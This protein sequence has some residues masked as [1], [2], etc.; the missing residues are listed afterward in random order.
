MGFAVWS[1][2]GPPTVC[3]G[4]MGFF[5][6]AFSGERDYIS[7]EQ[8]YELVWSKPLSGL[9]KDLGLSDAGLG[10]ICRRLDI[11]LPGRGAWMKADLLK[12]RPPLPPVPAGSKR[13]WAVVKPRQPEVDSRFP[14]RPEFP[15]DRRA[16]R[17]HFESLLG[18]F[19][20]ANTSTRHPEIRRTLREYGLTPAQGPV[21]Y[22]IPEITS[23]LGA[24]RARFA[25]SLLLALRR[26]GASV[27]I[28]D[29]EATQYTA[30]VD[31]QRVV[32]VID[33]PS[34]SSKLLPEVARTRL[35]VR[36]K[37]AS[38]RGNSRRT[39]NES[40]RSIESQLKEITLAI[41]LAAEDNRRALA[42]QTWQDE[43]FRI[44]REERETRAKA[45]AEARAF[46]DKLRKDAIQH[47]EANA[48]RELIRAVTLNL[49][50]S[51]RRDTWSRMALRHA[52]QLDPATNGTVLDRPGA[53]TFGGADTL[54]AWL[55]E[56]VPEDFRR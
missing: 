34:N 56:L 11:P 40:A 19:D 13:P 44:Q 38:G 51:E 47:S 35:M 29:R 32:F 46:T 27:A 52:E 6:P 5:A 42:V 41:L 8:L 12:R 26:A 43:V 25:N 2:T 16:R 24:R 21:H 48:I 45:L 10:K 14:P 49:P 55:A 39:W 7:R 23:R 28:E 9:A 31:G 36:L 22:G 50:P 33:T 15:N 1:M 30:L 17:V 4:P 20:A 53:S 3:C 18:D 37:N 54:S